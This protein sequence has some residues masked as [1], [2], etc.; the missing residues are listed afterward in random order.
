MRGGLSGWLACHNLNGLKTYT[1]L[2]VTMIFFAMRSSILSCYILILWY[3]KKS[4]HLISFRILKQNRKRRQKSTC[5]DTIKIII[6]II[7]NQ[8]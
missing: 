3:G 8:P 2:K 4:L 7:D 6:I 1:H 5:K